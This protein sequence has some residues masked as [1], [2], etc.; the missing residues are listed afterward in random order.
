MS[1]YRSEYLKKRIKYFTPEKEGD[2]RGYFEVAK[3]LG[4]PN[5]KLLTIKDLMIERELEVNESPNKPSGPLG[6]TNTEAAGGLLPSQLQPEAKIPNGEAKPNAKTKA[7]ASSA[8]KKSQPGQK[9]Q[10]ETK[11]ASKGHSS[12]NLVT[13]ALNQGDKNNSSQGR[14]RAPLGRQQANFK[15][16]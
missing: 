7:N 14:A 15:R 10:N 5:K 16:S 4:D 8:S 12:S 6:H 2:E 3:P 9:S 11:G 1:N 13:K